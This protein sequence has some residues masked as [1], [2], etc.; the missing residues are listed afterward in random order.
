[1]AL[2][3]A[4]GFFII[5]AFF[6]VSITLSI[7][8]S[9]FGQNRSS[10]SRK[11]IHSFYSHSLVILSFTIFLVVLRENILCV[12]PISI[13]VSR[14]YIP[15]IE[16]VAYFGA[17]VFL[18]LRV[19]M[20]QPGY[21]TGISGGL[22]SMKLLKLQ[23]LPFAENFLISSFGISGTPFYF[24]FIAIAF[25]FNNAYAY[26]ITYLIFLFGLYYSLSYFLSRVIFNT[27]DITKIGQQGFSFIFITIM[28][29][30]AVFI[31]DEPGYVDWVFG[32]PLILYS[33]I[34]IFRL[35]KGLDTK[36]GDYIKAVLPPIILS[37]ADPRFTIWF[38]MVILFL[39][40][41]AI[42]KKA[43][44][45]KMLRI[46]AYFI[47][48]GLPAYMYIYIVST[49]GAFISVYVS[50]R[51]LT[52]SGISGFSGAYPL[53]MYFAFHGEYWP[54]IWLS[55][56]AYI[57]GN[58]NSLASFGYPTGLI[59]GS[60]ILAYAWLSLSFIPFALSIV[61][62]FFRDRHILYLYPGYLLFFL[63]SIGGYAPAWF[64]D[65]YLWMGKLPIVGGIFGIAFAITTYFMQ[66]T[67]V[68]ALILCIAVFARLLSP[69]YTHKRYASGKKVY[70]RIYQTVFNRKMVAVLIV[71][72]FII[73]G[74]QFLDGSK[75]PSNWTPV[76]GGDGAPA[77]GAVT[78]VNPP[79]YWIREYDAIENQ[80]N[81]SFYVGYS[82]PYGFAYKWDDSVSG[83]S[84]PGTGAPSAFYQNLS[85]IMS[86]KETYLTE[87]LMSMFGV[88]YFIVDNTTVVSNS[89]YHKFFSES[90]GLVLYYSHSPDLWIYEDKNAS[91]IG[92]GTP[93]AYSGQ[94]DIGYSYLI[95][96][97]TDGDPLIMNGRTHHIPELLVNASMENGDLLAFTAE[98][99][100]DARGI[101]DFEGS[102]SFEWNASREGGPSFYIGG[103]W[104]IAD[105]YT[106]NILSLQEEGN[107]VALTNIS[108]K[109]EPQIFIELNG[110]DAMINVPSLDLRTSVAGHLTVQ[111]TTSIQ[112]FVTGYNSTGGVKYSDSEDVG[113]NGNFS[114]A[115]PIGTSYI[116]LGFIIDFHSS[117]IISNLRASYRFLNGSLSYDRSV[118][119]IPAGNNTA[120]TPNMTVD[121]FFSVASTNYPLGENWT[122]TSFTTGA[123]VNES[124][125]ILNLTTEND[126]G[127]LYGGLL[128]LAY[129]SIDLP[130]AT[131]VSV[132]RYKTTAVLV[133]ITMEY[134]FQGNNFT[135]MG[136]GIGA[137][138][139]S[140]SFNVPY[141][142]S[143]RNIS[144]TILIP[145]G[146]SQFN[147]QVSA[148]FNGSLLI[149]RLS[150]SYEFLHEENVSLPFKKTIEMEAGTYTVSTF[151]LGNGTVLLGNRSI[152]VSSKLPQLFSENII[153][154][155]NE[156]VTLQTSG[157]VSLLGIMIR[158]EK[159]YF[160]H[161]TISD[162]R[163]NDFTGYGS[164][165]VNG[166]EFIDLPYHVDISGATLVG[167]EHSGFFVYELKGSHTLTFHFPNYA[168]YNIAT[169]ILIIGIYSA[170]IFL[171]L[172]YFRKG[173]GKL[174]KFLGSV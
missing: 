74:Y 45:A 1:M 157:N 62:L 2:I 172:P 133:N 44:F 122:G 6:S 148:V 55:P 143:W 146:S 171:Y 160:S 140:A 144:E 158:P 167:E 78:S 54:Y 165:N 113:K 38:A 14:K 76:I 41:P 64:I 110:K 141:S 58:I 104:I 37:F 125:G 11:Q 47:V 49:F 27:F 153:V 28:L 139:Y 23:N 100:S 73:P 83:V 43:D 90:P 34:K 150:G 156:A 61:P 63:I 65:S 98:N 124:G 166:S 105:Y 111:G 40:I 71:L 169:V 137:S 17:L 69:K 72:A 121:R 174:V 97:L 117:V 57:S 164:V 119:Y 19:P 116:N 51:P 70:R 109:Q 126:N 168:A 123:L 130:G 16:H 9:L 142:A 13:C 173:F 48:I 84:Q 60:G 154:P 7:T 147:I 46:L 31:Y 53:F 95:S 161:G 82:Y 75:Y 8:E 20:T 85:E 96:K 87:T 32:I 127:K 136:I 151:G 120:N 112:A 170:V 149:K 107:A 129:K 25:I 91:I 162:F 18:I 66:I 33:I 52:L 118:S 36:R 128:V 3:C 106:N 145:P 103:Q 30:N 10:S 135:S 159:L 114:L 21:I 29:F 131:L 108:G 92:S 102:S 94:N 89:A 81:G 134:R 42:S 39:M 22:F 15:L 79:K 101:E 152:T 132:P 35:L 68:Y 24:P 99:L 115:V 163:I 26:A 86:L 59:L 5:P 155:A 77:I 56:T 50:A 67:I 88:R 138:N 93:I 12:L 80:S 4:T